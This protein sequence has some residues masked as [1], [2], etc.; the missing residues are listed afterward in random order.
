VNPIKKIKLSL[1]LLSRNNSS[2]LI[3]SYRT[4]FSAFS[5]LWFL[6]LSAELFD[7]EYLF[8]V[9]SIPGSPEEVTTLFLRQ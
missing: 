9:F 4:D 5:S 7:H 6:Y 1:N 8:E 2:L 3:F